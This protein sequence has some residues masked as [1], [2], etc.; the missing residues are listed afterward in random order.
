MCS[1]LPRQLKIHT[2]V[3]LLI[4]AAP[5]LPLQVPLASCGSPN[6]CA[7]FGSP[8]S[9]PSVAIRHVAEEFAGRRTIFKS[10]PPKQED[11]ERE[12]TR[13]L[14]I[15]YGVAREGLRRECRRENAMLHTVLVFLSTKGLQVMIS[16]VSKVDVV[17]SVVRTTTDLHHLSSMFMYEDEFT[18]PVSAKAP[19]KKQGT[20]REFVSLETVALW[21]LNPHGPGIA[22]RW[23]EEVV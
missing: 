5:L 6:P 8:P 15:L 14:P 4:F 3:F 2:L 12:E 1:N 7:D 21:G 18:P 10:R 11:V 19:P 23:K 20:L 22:W 13:A 17:G 16:R 9:P